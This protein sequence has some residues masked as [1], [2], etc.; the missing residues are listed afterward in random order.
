MMQDRDTLRWA[1][2]ALRVQ[3]VQERTKFA[4]A[5]S[6]NTWGPLYRAANAEREAEIT[7]LAAALDRLEQDV[8][9][10]GDPLLKAA[11]TLANV[12]L[13][14]MRVLHGRHPNRYVDP[15]YYR[16]PTQEQPLQEHVL[17]ELNGMIDSLDETVTQEDMG[18]VLLELR[19]QVRDGTWKS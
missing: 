17:A 16:P 3:H 15:D 7:I 6:D 2:I 8:E 1:V 19:D 10:A 11:V 18:R 5:S 9:H 12:Y 14:G 4:P 13:E